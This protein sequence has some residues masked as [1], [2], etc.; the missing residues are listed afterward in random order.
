MTQE[1][2][3]AY[4]KGYEAAK[5]KFAQ[6]LASLS[7]ENKRLREA[8]EGLKKGTATLR[9]RFAMAALTLWSQYGETSPQDAERIAKNVYCVADAMLA[10]RNKE[11]EK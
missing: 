6:D 2:W 3:D 11:K 1:D 7:E 5:A 8:M 4:D 9:D 10:E